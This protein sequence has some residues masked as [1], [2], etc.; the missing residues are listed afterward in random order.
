MRQNS[1]AEARV[2]GMQGAGPVNAALGA[3]NWAWC[4]AGARLLRALMLWPF[5]L[6]LTNVSEGAATPKRVLLVQSFGSAATPFTARLVAF[7]SE[8]ITKMGDRV[9]L[10]EVS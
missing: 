8:L 9:D 6:L 3:A 2:L 5:L 4:C 1:E 7:E 10:D